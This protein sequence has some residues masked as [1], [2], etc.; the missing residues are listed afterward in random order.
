IARKI[1]YVN[2][3]TVEFLVEAAPEEHFYFLEMNTR[4]QVEHPV[5]EAV[6]GVDLVQAQLLVAAGG[7]L[8]W[9]QPDLVPRG[10]AIECRVYAEDP[11]RGFLPQAG[12]LHV[13]REP[14][15]PWLRVDSGVEEGSEVSVHYDPLLAKLVSW[16]ETREMARARAVAALRRYPVLGIRTNVPF[17]VR[18]LEHECFRQATMDTAFLDAN[19]LTAG[20]PAADELASALAVAAAYDERAETP[21]DAPPDEGPWDRLERWGRIL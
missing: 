19:D 13:Y 11:D 6:L 7:P 16:G 20:T 12:R 17:L 1:G 14:R 8:P 5:T 15:G 9:R 4:L 3:G 10:H 18:V 21:A 2:A